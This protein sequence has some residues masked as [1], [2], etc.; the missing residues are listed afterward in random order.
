MLGDPNN[1]VNFRLQPRPEEREFAV[2]PGAPMHMISKKEFS[3][4]EMDT[5]RKSR[6]PKVVLTARGR[7]HDPRRSTSVRSQSLNLFVTV[8]F[9][10]ETLAV[11]SLGK[12]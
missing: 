3:S 7:V 6:T 10:E 9:V 11:L 8:Q 5:L 1:R 12:L 4:R 2:D